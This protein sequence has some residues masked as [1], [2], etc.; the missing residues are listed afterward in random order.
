[1]NFTINTRLKDAG[2]SLRVSNCLAR[3]HDIWTMYEMRNWYKRADGDDE[4]LLC[5][6]NFGTKSLDEVKD[7]LF[8]NRKGKCY[9]IVPS[10]RGKS[11]ARLAL[12]DLCL[13]PI[14]GDAYEIWGDLGNILLELDGQGEEGFWWPHTNSLETDEILDS[15]MNWFDGRCYFGEEDYKE[16]RKLTY[17]LFR[18]DY[19]ALELV[20]IK[21]SCT[22]LLES[23]E[24][25]GSSS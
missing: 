20:E 23:L 16:V 7:V 21:P 11:L 2:M 12:Y 17:A 22:E 8:P 5:T 24:T 19:I 25:T 18:N 15:L 14:G 13:G 10:D 1:M 4:V 3:N 6:R 9:K